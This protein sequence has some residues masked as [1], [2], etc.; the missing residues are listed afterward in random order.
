MATEHPKVLVLI[1]CDAYAETLGSS[2]DVRG[3]VRER[4]RVLQPRLSWT[5]IPYLSLHD[6]LRIRTGSR[7]CGLATGTQIFNSKTP[8]DLGS[9]FLGAVG[10]CGWRTNCMSPW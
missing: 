6:I 5:G 1:G 8:S 2:L 7:H 9:L 3:E 4:E 10:R